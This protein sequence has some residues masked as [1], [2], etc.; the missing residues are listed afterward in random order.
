[1][2]WSEGKHR[3]FSSSSIHLRVRLVRENHHPRIKDDLF[4]GVGNRSRIWPRQGR[5]TGNRIWQPV[6]TLNQIRLAAYISKRFEPTYASGKMIA[7]AEPSTRH[8][9]GT[10]DVAHTTMQPMITIERRTENQNLVY[11]R[12]MYMRT[13]RAKKPKSYHTAS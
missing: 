5:R 10:N 6:T 1:M 2:N 7:Q 8:P 9:S 13:L 12:D 3:T 11:G 4:D